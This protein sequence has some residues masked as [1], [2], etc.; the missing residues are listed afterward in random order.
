MSHQFRPCDQVLTLASQYGIPAMSQV[1][2][3]VFLSKGQKAEEP[4][5][6]HWTA[7]HDGWVVEREAGKGYGFFAPSQ[8]LPLRGDFAPER[9]KSQEVPA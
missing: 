7:P 8:L 4:D 3:V 6:D 5:G 9:Q 2:L 1:E